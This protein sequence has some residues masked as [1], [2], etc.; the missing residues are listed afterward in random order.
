MVETLV[1]IGVLGLFFAA[2]VVILHLVLKNIG[3][4]RVR[5]TG[6]ALA[7]SRM[8]MVRNLPYVDVG[9][10][11]GVPQGSVQPNE[12]VAMSGLTF[13]VTTSVVYIDDPYDG[14][15]PGDGNNADYKRR[16]LAVSG[17]GVFPSRMPVALV[18]NVAPK[19]LE[20]V[21]AGGTLLIKVFDSQGVAVTGAAVTVDNTSV[22]P[23]IHL[24]TL[25]DSSGTVSLPG[26]PP[27][28][29]CYQITVS[30]DGFSADR[31]YS[32]SEVAN[33]LQPPATVVEGGLTQLSFA[34]DRVA[35][36]TLISVGSR[37][38]GYPAVSNVLFT[39]RGSKT[40]G[41]D[42]NDEPVYKY[43]NSTNTGGGRVTL[44]DLEWGGYS[45]DFSN[46]GHDLAG[47]YPLVPFALNPG[48]SLE[49]KFVAVP[50]SANSLLLM[51]KDTAT[52]E[53]VASAEATL[54]S[55]QLSFTATESAGASG[56]ADFGQAFWGGIVGSGTYD[57]LVNMTGYNS[58]T[59]SVTISGAT[60]ETL[61]LEPM[62]TP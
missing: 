4:S 17:G 26:S 3:E 39:I 24:T 23:V 14:V 33:P 54:S 62:P 13:T 51:L 32:A 22:N 57:L 58:A 31:T 19:G 21:T 55:A 59:S 29:S 35:S 50:R 41:Y 36:A 20:T 45:L 12:T 38:A 47:S 44:S 9:T 37:E 2:V 8:E 11:G 49:V 27:C 60:G 53:L 48:A 61:F 25:T 18:T 15:A 16:R 6:L 28:V 34:I 42:V 40:I 1:G 52:T 46:S 7:Q 30:K 10:V 43:V 5:A 56:A